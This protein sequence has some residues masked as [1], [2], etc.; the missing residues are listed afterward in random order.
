MEIFIHMAYH[1]IIEFPYV[2]IDFSYNSNKIKLPYA[3]SI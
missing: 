3:S 2:N 1:L